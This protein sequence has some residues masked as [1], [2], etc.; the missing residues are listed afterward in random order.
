L[1]RS[2][3]LLTRST[4][5]FVATVLNGLRPDEEGYPGYFGY[6]KASQKT[7]EILKAKE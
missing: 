4:N 1:A 2:Y 7:V 3:Q 6:R 5:H